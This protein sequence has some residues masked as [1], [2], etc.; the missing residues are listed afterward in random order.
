MILETDVRMDFA[1]PLLP[2]GQHSGETEPVVP[3]SPRHHLL[4]LVR[5]QPLEVDRPLRLRPRRGDH[6]EREDQRERA[7]RGSSG[8]SLPLSLSLRPSTLQTCAVKR[9]THYFASA[10][11][12][13]HPSNAGYHKLLLRKGKERLSKLRRRFYATGGGWRSEGLRGDRLLRWLAV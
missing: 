4:R 3:D 11:P 1:K 12:L 7:K 6:Y 5:R 10:A 2:R 13:R 9:C 8:H